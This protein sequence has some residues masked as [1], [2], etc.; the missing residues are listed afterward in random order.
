MATIYNYQ[1]LNITAICAWMT[2]KHAKIIIHVFHAIRDSLVHNANSTVLRVTVVSAILQRGNVRIF[3][4]P[5][6]IS[7]RMV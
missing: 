4:H 7:I 5:M 1:E 3:A 6:N 2:V